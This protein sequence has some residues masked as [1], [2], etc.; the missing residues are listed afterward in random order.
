LPSNTSCHQDCEQDK[1]EFGVESA[2]IDGHSLIVGEEDVGTGKIG[3]SKQY[4][5]LVGMEEA[6]QSAS[7][8]DN[9]RARGDK[10]KVSAKGHQTR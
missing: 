5:P 1:L 2:L 7:P 4:G 8:D 9:V 3:I 6:D 10:A